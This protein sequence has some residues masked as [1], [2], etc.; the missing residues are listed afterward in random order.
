MINFFNISLAMINLLAP[1]ICFD[2]KKR[3]K[4]PQKVDIIFIS[5]STIPYKYRNRWYLTI[6]FPNKKCPF[7]DRL[8]HRTFLTHCQLISPFCTPWKHWTTFCFLV[9]SGGVKWEHLAENGSSYFQSSLFLYLFS[10]RLLIIGL[11]VNNIWQ[12]VSE[13][14]KC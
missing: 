14:S 10:V 8:C 6:T 2:R 11:K 13:I 7:R 1:C 3:K 9:F 4:M 5:T 12:C